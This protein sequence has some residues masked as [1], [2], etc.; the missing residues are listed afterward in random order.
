VEANPALLHARNA[1]GAT[2]LDVA[3]AQKKPDVVSLL[4]RLV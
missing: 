4:E 1:Q 2:L 3:R